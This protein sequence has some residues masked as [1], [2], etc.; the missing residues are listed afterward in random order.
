MNET[1]EPRT[2]LFVGPAGHLGESRVRK[3]NI[4]HR[5][6]QKDLDIVTKTANCCLSKARPLESSNDSSLPPPNIL[7]SGTP[8]A[9][10]TPTPQSPR[11][12]ALSTP[13]RTH[14][15]GSGTAG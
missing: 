2:A 7:L 4:M 10:C 3:R 8:C 15:I 11:A 6:S 1:A 5:I 14:G 9:R 12:S 13:T